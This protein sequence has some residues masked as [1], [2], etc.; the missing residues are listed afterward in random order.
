MQ[1]SAALSPAPSPT[2][3]LLA[4]VRAQKK[5]LV[6]AAAIGNGLVT[7]DFTVYSFSAVIIG[8]L[9]FPSDS[10]LASLLMALLTFG[11]GFAMRPIGAL[12]IG[13]L[14][15]RKGRKAG[16]TLSI[17]LM[18]LAT[19][20]IAFAPTYSSIGVASMLLIVC[21]RLLQGFAAG[22][23]IG[24]SSVVL[25]ELAAKGRRCYVVSW[26]SASQAAA[27]LAGALVGACTTAMMTPEALH[28]WGWRI[29]FILGMLIGPVGW[30]IRR[31]MENTPMKSP[32]R[33]SVKAMLAQHARTL[34]LG[35]LL[36]AAPTAGIYLMVYYMPIYLVGT[37]HM[38]PMVSLLS[39][40]LS[41]TLI[42]IGVPLMA[43]V[44]DRQRLRKPIQYATIISSIVLVYPAFL[45]LT[46]GIGEVSSLLVIGGYSALL[47]CGNAATTVMILEAFPRHHRATGVSM[48]YS[49]GTTIF[50]AFCPFIVAWLIGV[51]GNP[52]VPAWYLLAALCI[53]LFALVR[54]PGNQ[55]QLRLRNAGAL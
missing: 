50:G 4:P 11:A 47:L 26:R 46:R 32:H 22:G 37:L 36:M 3:Q 45:L 7:Y 10:A 23:E 30:Y 16:L 52:M 55:E 9:F 44:A 34:G 25:M 1:G 5:R 8:K 2:D 13:N 43:R 35:I 19:G 24:V 6:W 40:C 41:S 29:P 39:A 49:L 31:N 33:S 20:M 27:A 53:S 14:A 28:Q 48:I 12:V 15:D 21:G 38:L 18:T 42:F 54:F 51:T 17:V